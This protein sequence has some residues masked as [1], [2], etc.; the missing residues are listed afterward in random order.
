MY[1]YVLTEYTLS[2]SLYSR[3]MS[4]VVEGERQFVKE[5]GHMILDSVQQN[6]RTFPTSLVATVLLQHPQGIYM[7]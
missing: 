3:D 7:G 5:L 4:V 1:M 6:M 2:L